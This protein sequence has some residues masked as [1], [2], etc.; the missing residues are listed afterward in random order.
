MPLRSGYVRRVHEVWRSDDGH[1]MFMYVFIGRHEE[2]R[3]PLDPATVIV[4]DLGRDIPSLV[5]DWAL[6]AE[7]PPGG[8]PVAPPI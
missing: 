2:L 1:D 6:T 5:R 4:P 3:P 7:L 8:D